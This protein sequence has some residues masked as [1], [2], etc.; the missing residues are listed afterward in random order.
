MAKISNQQGFGLVELMIALMLSLVV[1]AGLYAAFIGDQKSYELTRASHLLVNKN[2][3]SIQT[4]RL[5]IQQ[6]GFRDYNQLYQNTLLPVVPVAD[7]LGFTW[8]EAQMLQGLENQTTYPGAKADTDVVALRFYG[9]AAPNA[10]LYACDG[11]EVAADTVLTMVFFI[12]TSDQLVCRDP[13]GD[14]VFDQDIDNLQL[15]YASADNNFRYF[16]AS[17][18]TDWTEI[19]RVKIGLLVAQDVTMGSLSR[20][21]KYPVL[22]EEITVN[23]KKLRQ[24]VS[25]T[26]ML[27]NRGVS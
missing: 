22:D 21:H 11:S 25:E 14:T 1:V 26:V 12:S 27:L 23:D 24:A 10:S 8:D 2:R 20:N 6:A 13:S 3:M 19:N 9:A 17:Q 16:K 4:M 7:T 18:V 5:Y 15:L